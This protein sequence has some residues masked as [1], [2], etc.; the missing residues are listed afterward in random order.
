MHWEL[1]ADI[2]KLKNMIINETFPSE[3][4]FVQESIAAA[5]SALY[6]I[7]H[8]PFGPICKD[9][10]CNMHNMGIQE[11]LGIV[12]MMGKIK[13]SNTSYRIVFRTGKWQ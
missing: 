6:Q 9:E 8:E 12:E 10:I 4:T 2:Q 7:K 1:K 3:E 5:A 11:F 13:Q